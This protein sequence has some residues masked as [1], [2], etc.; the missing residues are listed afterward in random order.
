M[1]RSSRRRPFAARFVYAVGAVAA[2]SRLAPRCF[3]TM[4]KTYLWNAALV[5]LGGSVGA[6]LRFVLSG[7]VHRVLPTITLPIGTLF[8]NVVGCLVIG[9]LTGL[10]ETRQLFGPQSRLFL[11][12]G[13]LGSFTTFSTFAYETLALTQQADFL[14][15]SG[16]V[17]IQVILC[18]ACVWLGFAVSRML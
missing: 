13:V 14:R 17:L 18:L 5:G 12:I 2:S 3:K 16:N 6:V 15:A 8:V 11:F 4:T 9:F 1:A 10:V 7:L